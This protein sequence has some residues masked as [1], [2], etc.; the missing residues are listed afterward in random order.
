MSGST[1]AA[2]WKAA[3]EV[4]GDGQWIPTLLCYVRRRELFRRAGTSEELFLALSD[5]CPSWDQDTFMVLCKR[6]VVHEQSC[7]WRSV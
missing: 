4:L 7:L 5:A 6:I 3:Y 1:R 2:N